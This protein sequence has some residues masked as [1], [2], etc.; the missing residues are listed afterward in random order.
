MYS[1]ALL[2]HTNSLQVG[3]CFSVCLER[4]NGQDK[5]MLQ[6]LQSWKRSLLSRARFCRRCWGKMVETGGHSGQWK[7][8][9]EVHNRIFRK[10]KNGKKH[11]MYSSD[12]IIAKFKTIIADDGD[13]DRCG[14][15]KVWKTITL[16]LARWMRGFPMRVSCRG[17]WGPAA[18][19]WRGPSQSSNYTATWEQST[20]ATLAERYRPGI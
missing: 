16:C 3:V 5:G 6:G 18:G 7:F 9:Q 13:L 8:L 4:E 11:I 10:I 12:N 14:Y 17:F 20:D 1:F 19:M 2:C 15:N